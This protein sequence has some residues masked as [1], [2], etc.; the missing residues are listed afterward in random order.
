M[1]KLV[2][3]TIPDTVIGYGVMKLAEYFNAPYIISGIQLI[4]SM[5]NLLQIVSIIRNRGIELP[6]LSPQT[7]A[8]EP[9]HDEKPM[10]IKP[11]QK[12][13]QPQL[14]VPRDNIPT[15]TLLGVDA[16]EYFWPSSMA[17]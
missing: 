17:G 2:I 9:K 4:K 12:Q 11:F 8:D 3:Q 7:H 6:E 5:H 13:N 14:N 10:Q 16:N 15:V 1:R